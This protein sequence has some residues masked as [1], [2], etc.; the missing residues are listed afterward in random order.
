MNEVPEREALP[1]RNAA[2]K[3]KKPATIDPKTVLKFRWDLQEMPSSQHRAGLA[4]LALCVAFL[5]RRPDRKGVCEIESIDEQ[6]LVL[7][8][9]RDGMQ[10]LFDDIYD[11]SLEE[12]EREK[13]LQKKLA[14]GTKVDIE[15]KRPAIERVFVD[16]K[17][18][19]EKKRK[20]FIYDQVI[21]RGALVDDWD[22][23]HDGKKP[24]LKLWRDMVWTTLRGVPATREPFDARAE[25]RK[26]KDGVEAWDELATR[27][28]TTVDLPSTYALG[29]Q[30][31]SAENV[32]FQDVARL[33]FL[34]HFWPFVAAIYVPAL[35][36]RDL[37]R[38]FAGYAL[39]IPD[40]ADLGDFVRAWEQVARGRS[41]ELSGYV[42]RDAVIDLAAEAGLDVVRRSNEVV[43]S[44]QGAS[45][46]RPWLNAVDVFHV[47][48]EGNNVRLRGIG[49]VVPERKQ[50]DQYARVRRGNYWSPLF[51][52]QR[53]SNVLDRKP[54]WSGF[55]RLC[56]TTPDE[57]TIRHN[58]FRRDCRLAL[59]EVEVKD[60]VP[61]TEQTL[62]H[63]IFRRVQAYVL[64]KTERKYDLSWQKVQGNAARE[65]EY[66]ERKEKV[67]REAFLA[68]RSRTGADFVSY[69]TST[70]CSVPQRASEGKYLEIARALM[71]SKSIEQVRS[72]TLLAL[73]AVA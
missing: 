14:D 7:A 3:G 12:Q 1:K 69:F 2:Q 70:L 25:E 11:A 27:P 9:D 62:E 73:S 66:G 6:A 51:R 29:A 8:A 28:N 22:A 64:G 43:A 36:K 5:K 58:S 55:A 24:W 45:S 61:E 63:L 54:W 71:D 13:K 46:T 37:S 31:K 34:L 15:P 38:D 48:K 47:E 49:R 44:S 40:V 60:D 17:T 35:L 18:K 23:G 32:P 33:R 52:R 16:P 10:S 42:P 68:I 59:T 72:L 56:A 4:G 50:D 65:K 21:P 41:G 26:S 67:A 57:M 19:A 30:A 20:V 39:A 53:V